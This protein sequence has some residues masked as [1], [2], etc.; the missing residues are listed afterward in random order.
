MTD[1][2]DRDD[3]T[4]TDDSRTLRAAL[5]SVQ[6]GVE[7]STRDGRY[8]YVNEFFA[9]FYGRTRND[10]VGLTARD[11]MGPEVAA[12]M[13]EADARV[14]ATGEPVGFWLHT[15]RDAQAITRYWLVGKW[16]FK[17]HGTGEVGHIVT[18]SF[19]V[20]E[21][22]TARLVADERERQ[23][24]A[25][26][27]RAQVMLVT[28]IEPPDGPEVVPFVDGRIADA[29]NLDKEALARDAW[30]I[31]DCVH[32]DD[33]ERSLKLWEESKRRGEPYVNEFRFITSDGDVRWVSTTAVHHRQ[34]DGTIVSDEVMLDMTEL[35]RARTEAQERYNQ[36]RSLATTVPGGIARRITKPDGSATIPFMGGE[37][38]VRLGIDTA[39]VAQDASVAWR[40][41]HPEDRDRT[42]RI[43]QELLASMEPASNTARFIDTDGRTVWYRSRWRHHLLDGGDIATDTLTIDVTEEMLAQERLERERKLVQS[44]TANIP[45]LIFRRVNAPDGSMRYDFI[46]GGLLA[47]YGVSADAA[48]LDPELIWQHFDPTDLD[49]VRGVIADA[50]ANLEPFSYTVRARLPTTGEHRHIEVS[51]TPKAMPDGSIVT[52]GIAVDATDRVH[53][54]AEAREQRALL[55]QVID[56][57]PAAINVKNRSGHIELANRALADYCG[58]RPEDLLWTSRAQTQ[59]LPVEDEFTAAWDRDVLDSGEVSAT[60]ELA[61]V[62]PQGRTRHWI[63]RKSPLRDPATGIVD[64]VVTVSLEVT[65]RVEAERR[66][67]EAEA[68]LSSIAENLPGMI[69]RRVHHGKERATIAYASGRLASALGLSRA[70]DDAEKLWRW[71]HPDD[72]ERLIT[73]L[74]QMSV[75]GQSLETLDRYLLPDGTMRWVR[76]LSHPRRLDDGTMVSDAI[77]L[78]VTE[79]KTAEDMARQHDELLRSV[80]SSIPG[81]ILRWR[82]DASGLVEQEYVAGRLVDAGLLRSPEGRVPLRDIW[83]SLREEDAARLLSELAEAAEGRSRLETELRLA[84][85]DELHWIRLFA[86][87]R[88][89]RSDIDLWD[90]IALDVTESRRYEEQLRI[91]QKMDAIG[92][93][94]GGIAHDFNNILAI[95][96]ANL[97]LL[98]E[99]DGLPQEELRSAEAALAA[100][101][102]GADL[103]ARLLSYARSRPTELQPVSCNERIESLAQLME[104]T[105]GPE[106]ELD[107]RDSSDV[108][109]VRVDPS[110][111]ETAIMNLVV[112]ARDA[113]DSR[114]SIIVETRGVVFEAEDSRPPGIAPGPYAVVSVTD[115]GCGMTPEVQR[116]VFE[117]LFTTKGEGKGTGY[118]LTMVYNFARDAGGHVTLYS[119]PGLGTTVRIYLPALDRRWEQ[120]VKA[121]AVPCGP[122]PLERSARVLLVD[123]NVE[124]RDALAR[125]LRRAGYT[126]TEAA[127][128]DEALA[129]FGG[130]SG[131]DILISDVIMPGTMSGVDLADRARLIRPDLPVLLLSGYP[132]DAL[133]AR[134]PV[135]VPY[136]IMGKPL[137]KSELLAAVARHLSGDIS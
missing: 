131:F 20:T 11:V 25:L 57:M 109:L 13:E 37:F 125:Q 108:P 91:A 114:G 43:W 76:N 63:G 9:E 22:H 121:D 61:Y 36:I 66:A 29:L 86:R 122:A 85:D 115:F 123:D 38:A 74:Y 70:G 97:D 23:L 31:L 64:R 105:L 136:E 17:A 104:R 47:Q 26:T 129:T 117:P 55:Q 127:S 24:Q 10:I 3:G 68:R 137:R 21:L 32:P 118:G 93:L 94:T 75:T 19:D 80:A 110:E 12:E 5:D 111:F 107:L 4:V 135:P 106:V 14:V 133:V 40:A 54:E 15:E 103:T 89:G 16:P 6:A 18:M 98:L 56:A 81:A 132:S 53:A 2:R 83:H 69:L 7:I 78:D 41:I 33:H 48:L 87:Q 84:G 88:R 128:G 77:L 50:V 79:R 82:I 59:D 126:V 62:D 92:N 1:G 99:T 49:D 102:R 46:Q 8:I 72:R 34:H 95:I 100:A 124:G 35:H 51:G 120:A 39:A 58:V 60:R 113:L 52:D 96:V 101:E 119:E 65:D 44:V 67:R 27:S 130:G 73:Q 112:N 116:R 45:G 42:Q 71:L 30:A 90:I 134:R 28:T